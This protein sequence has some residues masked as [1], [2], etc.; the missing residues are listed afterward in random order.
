MFKQR[1][2]PLIFRFLIRSRLMYDSTFVEPRATYESLF[3]QTSNDIIAGNG[4]IVVIRY[5]CVFD[6]HLLAG[7]DIQYRASDS[8]S[9]YTM[10]FDEIKSK[11]NM[12]Q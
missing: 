5:V 2:Q 10:P 1:C 7:R 9:R 6:D 12:Q 11:C 3:F 8:R 4:I